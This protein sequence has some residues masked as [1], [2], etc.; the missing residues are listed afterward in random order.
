MCHGLPGTHN[1]C[2]YSPASLFQAS[3]TG[4]LA[5]LTQNLLITNCVSN[6]ITSSR[7]TS[8]LLGICTQHGREATAAFTA[9]ML[10]SVDCA[11]LQRHTHRALDRVQVP[12]KPLP[13]SQNSKF[14]I[15]KLACK[16]QTI[17]WQAVTLA[18]LKGCSKW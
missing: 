16:I 14:K 3:G 8:P 6:P 10:L 15:S 5:L 13:G 4:I 1:W 12:S 11:L 9:V 17:K 2:A 18:G 7:S